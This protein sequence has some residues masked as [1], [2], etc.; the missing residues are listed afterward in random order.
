MDLFLPKLVDCRT[1]WFYFLWR[2]RRSTPWRRNLLVALAQY[3]VT[4]FDRHRPT[5]TKSSSWFLSSLLKKRLL[6]TWLA[7]K[8]GAIFSLIYFFEW[9]CI[10]CIPHN[11]VFRK[12]MPQAILQTHSAF[13]P[14]R[15]IIWIRQKLSKH[16]SYQ[17]VKQ[18]KRSVIW[19]DK[20]CT[21]YVQNTVSKGKKCF[22][23]GRI[24]VP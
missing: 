16:Q 8:K 10:H 5:S 17:K 6:V 7:P 24:A 19:I 9:L 4:H 12:A 13:Y 22:N 1:T 14:H 21:S 3:T 15:L 11:Y 23:P 18:A 2:R 20:K